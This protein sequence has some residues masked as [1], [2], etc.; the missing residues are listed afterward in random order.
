MNILEVNNLKKLFP[1]RTIFLKK[2]DKFIHAVDD[3]SFQIKKGESFGLVGETGSGKTTTAR[4]ILRL[5]EPDSGEIL[6]NNENIMS[7]KGKKLLEY[8]KRVQ[9]IF[10]DPSSA[11]NPRKT[12]KYILL[13]PMEIHNLYTKQEIYENLINLLKKVNLNPPESF[14]DKYPHELSGGQKQRIIIARALSLNPELI[15]MDEPVSSLD[16]SLRGQILNLMKELQY[17]SNLTYLLISHDISVVYWFCDKVAVMY[18]GKIVEILK[19][20]E[21][22]NNPLHPYTKGL[23]E[24]VL[25]PDPKERETSKRLILK[26][27]IPSPINPPLGCRFVDRCPFAVKICK[28]EEPKLKYIEEDHMVA[29]HLY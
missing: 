3:V 24:S 29:C 25:K 19:G 2:T 6:F 14:L 7:F 26:G 13:R 12:I 4:L 15:I 17:K 22:L 20:S 11:L 28:S 5:I 18:F 10:Q 27:E 23:I 8:R 1:I 21:I 9:M 16:V